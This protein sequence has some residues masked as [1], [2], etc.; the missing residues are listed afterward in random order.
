MWTKNNVTYFY[1]NI[2]VIYLSFVNKLTNYV[3]MYV[4]V[5]VCL[6]I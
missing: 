6:C 4:Y 3:C 5:C 2:T 1:L